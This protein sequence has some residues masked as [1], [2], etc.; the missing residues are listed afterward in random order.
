MH[1]VFELPVVQCTTWSFAQ[2]NQIIE[3]SKNKPLTNIAPIE[4]QMSIRFVFAALF[5]REKL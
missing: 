4:R 2:G 1:L 3:K 5:L